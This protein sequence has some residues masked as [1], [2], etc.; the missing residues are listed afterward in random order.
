MGYLVCECPKCGR[1][2][3]DRLTECPN[4]TRKEKRGVNRRVSKDGEKVYAVP[5][6]R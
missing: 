2:L 6:R 1:P 3:P 5:S 4:C